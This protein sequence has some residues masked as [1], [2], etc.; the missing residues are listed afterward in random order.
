MVNPEYVSEGVIVG[1]VAALLLAAAAID[2]YSR[3]IPNRL[4][5]AIA[6]LSIPYWWTTGLAL[7]PDVAW[8]VGIAAVSFVILLGIFHIGQMGGGD[9]KLLVALALFLRPTDYLWMV[10]GMAMI[11]GVMTS[12]MLIHHRIRRPDRPFENPYGIAIAASALLVIAGHYHLIDVEPIF[13]ALF[14]IALV[15]CV[16]TLG[17]LI[18]LR[19]RNAQ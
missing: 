5:L 15:G 11:G 1:L 13:A 10:F 19:L 17:V 2:G 3:I 12:A 8:Q 18:G 6:L 7:W 4:N 14:R 9:V 16:V